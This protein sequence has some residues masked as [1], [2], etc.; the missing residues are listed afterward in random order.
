MF[1]NRPKEGGPGTCLYQDPPTGC[2]GTLTGGFWAPVA[3]R[4]HLFEGPGTGSYQEHGQ[5]PLLL[6][7]WV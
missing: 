1:M 5:I 2:F 3:T 4:K 7:I 6:R